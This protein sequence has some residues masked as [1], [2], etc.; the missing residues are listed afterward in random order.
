MQ[1]NALN[2]TGIC[3][4]VGAPALPGVG[5]GR[6]VPGDLAAGLLD[7]DEAVGIDWAWLSLRRRDQEGA[8]GR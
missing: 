4:S 7:Y 2:A 1:W 5:A 6:G 3:S 8:A